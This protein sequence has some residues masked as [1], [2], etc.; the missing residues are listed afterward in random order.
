MA[1][2][3]T[4]EALQELQEELLA[5]CQHQLE[6]VH[7]LEQALSSHTET[8]KN[9][10]DKPKRNNSSRQTVESGKIDHGCPSYMRGGE[11]TD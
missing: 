4:L 5:V 2:A 11:L 1:T 10:L 6:N 3:G 8:F 7:V 9:F